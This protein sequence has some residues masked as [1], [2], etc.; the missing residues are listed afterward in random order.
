ML[1]NGNEIEILAPAGNFE[2]LKTAIL[3]GADSVYFGLGN[4]NARRNAKNFSTFEE[5]KEAVDFCHLRGKKAHVTLNTLVY[6]NERRENLIKNAN[7]FIQNFSQNIFE[8][9]IIDFFGD[10]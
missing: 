2:N 9:R 1:V 6:D 8:K 5:V 4:F 7:S 10:L 3:S